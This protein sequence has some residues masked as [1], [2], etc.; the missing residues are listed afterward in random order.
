MDPVLPT[1]FRTQQLSGSG[2][3][4]F[5]GLVEPDLW[6]TL[7]IDGLMHVVADDRFD[8]PASLDLLDFDSLPDLSPDFPLLVDVEPM[9]SAADPSTDLPT[10]G[11]GRWAALLG[12]D[13]GDYVYRPAGLAARDP[14]DLFGDGDV[15]VVAASGQAP[16]VELVTVTTDPLPY[17]GEIDVLVDPLPLLPIISVVTDPLPLL[18]DDA[19]ADF[20][21]PFADDFLLQPNGDLDFLTLD[22]PGGAVQW[23]DPITST[24]GAGLGWVFT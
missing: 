21:T 17:I 16:D 22:D 9:F 14:M 3:S 15:P 23:Q 24:T 19:V 6:A 12:D 4:Q 20:F 8:L 11:T 18:G 1:A 13:G 7:D 5:G 10:P 2:L